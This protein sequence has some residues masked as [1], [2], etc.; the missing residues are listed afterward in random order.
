M[1]KK[2]RKRI[3]EYGRRIKPYL[4]PNCPIDYT[5]GL[6]T[7][8]GTFT[9]PVMPPKRRAYPVIKVEMYDKQALE[10]A[11]PCFGTKVT[12]A[13][14]RD[15][16]PVYKLERTHKAAEDLARA[17]SVTERRKKQI[18]DAMNKCRQTWR[19]GYRH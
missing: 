7:A 1:P 11:Q 2:R 16:T 13:G 9:C 8:D 12:S 10:I 18:E 15:E 4:L 6:Y 14:K 17:L 3:S 5:R 19:K